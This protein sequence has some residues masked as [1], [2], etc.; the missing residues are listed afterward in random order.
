MR[1]FLQSLAALLSVH[2]GTLLG[3][4]LLP[5]ILTRFLGAEAL[6]IFTFAASFGLLLLTV[7]DWGYETRL[8]ILAASA[9]E[10]SLRL[11]TQAQAAKFRLWLIVISIV[12]LFYATQYLVNQA[13]IRFAPLSFVPLACYAVWAI[14]RGMCMTYSAVLR[15]LQRFGVIARIENIL[16]ILSHSVALMLVWGNGIGSDAALLSNK[17]LSLL[18]CGIIVCFIVGESV[19]YLAFRRELQRD[20]IVPLNSAPQDKQDISESPSLPS[21]SHI[22]SLHIPLSWSHLVFVMMQAISII[23]SRAG[24]YALMFLSTPLEI[25]LAGAVMRFT[26]A[27]RLLPGALFHVL[28]PRFVRSPQ[29]ETLQKALTLGLGIGLT[30]SIVLYSTAEWLIGLLYGKQFLYLVPLLQLSSWLFCLQTL[31]QIAESYLL[32][33][34]KEQ[35][36]NIAMFLCLCGF[37]LLCFSTPSLTASAAIVYSL[38]LEGVLLLAFGVIILKN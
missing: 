9:P 12:A 23:Q 18:L 17:H 37:G 19:K 7:I 25:G 31:G 11:I 14:V 24:I 21:S 8:P 5:I 2:A 34:K 35:L 30:G 4:T 16:T 38:V 27:M 20:W 26:I 33:Q 28:L 13:Y 10:T 22:F 1:S 6:G 32:A 3:G 15:G 36:V 29:S